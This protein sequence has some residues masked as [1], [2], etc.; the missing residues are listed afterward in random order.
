MYYPSKCE[1]YLARRGL[2]RLKESGSTTIW[3]REGGE[4]D[5]W[6]VSYEETMII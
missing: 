6:E 2:G 3:L 4:H 5:I 1:D